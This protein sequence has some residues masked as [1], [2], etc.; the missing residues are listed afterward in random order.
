MDSGVYRVV[1]TRYD[2]SGQ[3]LSSREE[4]KFEIADDKITEV[5][6]GLKEIIERGDTA[7]DAQRRLQGPYFR[8]EKA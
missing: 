5:S 2:E 7:Q 1:F 8:I 4:G 3:P 6:Q